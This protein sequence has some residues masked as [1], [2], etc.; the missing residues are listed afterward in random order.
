MTMKETLRQATDRLAGR[1][2]EDARLESEI[3]LRQVLQLSRVE[4]YQELD[5][6]LAPKEADDFQCLIQRR[7]SGE[8]TAYITGH[9]EFYGLDFQ[10]NRHVLIPRPETELLVERALALAQER[11]PASIADIGTG[12]GAVAVSLAINLP[13]S[14][15][16]ATDISAAALEIA[17]ANCRRHGVSNRITLLTGDLLAPLPE[18]VD[19]IVAN[20]PYVNEEE[21]SQTNTSRFEPETALNGG[22]D[23]LDEIR[24][25]CRDLATKIRAGG[26]LLLEIGEGQGRPLTAF[27]WE[28]LPAVEIELTPDLS[29][30]DRVLR[31][32]PTAKETGP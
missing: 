2:I 31:V 32:T 8:P 21:V 5:R 7:L 14:S 20:L 1:D 12:C 29:G 10:V 27:L 13:Q 9:R 30:I 11:S 17:R 15:I 25:L 26:S 18:P 19:L 4:L 28:L 22:R 24:R 6:K 23:G 16:Y 3:L